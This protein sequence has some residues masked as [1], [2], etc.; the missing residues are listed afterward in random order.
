MVL[1][2]SLSKGAKLTDDTF[3]WLYLQIAGRL[4]AGRLRDSFMTAESTVY[5]RLPAIMNHPQTFVA[6]ARGDFSSGLFRDHE[7]VA[8]GDVGGLRGYPVNFIGGSRRLMMHL[9]DRVAVAQD[10]FH[11]MSLG[12][13]GFLDRARCGAGAAPWR[14][15][16]FSLRSE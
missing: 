3:G 8:G 10:L 16:I 9:E 12:V 15:R 2:S 7:F 5:Q 14:R 11:L 6:D 13:V 4:R 1:G